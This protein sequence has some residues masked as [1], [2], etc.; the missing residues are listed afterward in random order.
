MT[1]LKAKDYITNP[2]V[3]SPTARAYYLDI[4]RGVAQRCTKILSRLGTY[5]YV[6]HS[7]FHPIVRVTEGF[8]AVRHKFTES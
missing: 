8:F 6:S 5:I 1:G 3:L 4:E 7:I 2:E